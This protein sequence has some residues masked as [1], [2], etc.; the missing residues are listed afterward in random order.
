M[1]GEASTAR[2][3]GLSTVSLAV[4]WSTRASSASSSATSSS[5]AARERG[6]SRWWPA[7]S[8]RLVR[9]TDDGIGLGSS[10]GGLTDPA[11]GAAG[12]RC[13]AVGDFLLRHRRPGP[14]DPRWRWRSGK[15]SRRH[16]TGASK[17][18]DRLTRR[19]N[20]LSDTPSGTATL[21]VSELPTDRRHGG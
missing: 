12:P 3:R 18:V 21:T 16:T 17:V 4:R 7:G 5:M 6:N 10:H 1:S 8:V 20:A 11:A 15:W 14:T 2:A 13:G 9:F 19:H